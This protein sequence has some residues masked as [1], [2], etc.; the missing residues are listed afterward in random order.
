M[1]PE[2]DRKEFEAWAA[3]QAKSPWPMSPD[4][5][6]QAL[7]NAHGLLRRQ[8]KGVPLWSFIADITSHGCGYSIEICKACGWNPDQDAGKP[9]VH[10]I[11]K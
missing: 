3:E 9:I 4:R 10:E 11:S 6:K 1:N 8:Y 7:R 2:T 5:Q